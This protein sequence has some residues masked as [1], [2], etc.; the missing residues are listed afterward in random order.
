M[1]EKGLV[2]KEGKIEKVVKE[3]EMIE[4]Y[5]LEKITA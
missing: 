1:I 5:A 2:G 4:D 3:V